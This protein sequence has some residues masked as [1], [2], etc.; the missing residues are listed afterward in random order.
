MFEKVKEKLTIGDQLK[1]A[2]M[3]QGLTQVE[4]WEKSRVS[5]F[6]I[7]QLELNHVYNASTHTLR[8]LQFA[9]GIVFEI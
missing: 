7:G 5:V 6:T 4:L 9:L 8:A 3:A 1:N 2:R